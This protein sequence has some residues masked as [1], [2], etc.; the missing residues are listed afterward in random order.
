MY[1]FVIGREVSILAIGYILFYRFLSGKD[2]KS[3][4]KEVSIPLIFSLAG[5]AI[6]SIIV[7]EPGY[8]A[9]FYSSLLKSLESS[10]IV[11]ELYQ[12]IAT[13]HVGWIPILITLLHVVRKKNDPL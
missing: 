8:T 2:V 13:Y 9:Y 7:P 4:L 11:K 10:K 3:T 5:I 6:A 1:I 12:V